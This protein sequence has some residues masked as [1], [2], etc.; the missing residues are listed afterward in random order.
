MSKIHCA[1][2]TGKDGKALFARCAARRVG[3]GK[4]RRNDRATY[5]YM[6]SEIVSAEDFRFNTKPADRCAHCV[7]LALEGRNRV[8]KEKGLPPVDSLDAPV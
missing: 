7:G 3:N 8:R 2:N 1:A 5:G 4:V 6:A